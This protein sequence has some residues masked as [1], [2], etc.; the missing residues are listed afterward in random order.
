MALLE[1]FEPHKEASA[2]FTP[3][4][5]A[6]GQS[7]YNP[8]VWKRED[9]EDLIEGF[10][11]PRARKPFSLKTRL[12]VMAKT[13]G[14]CYS[15]GEKFNDPSEVWIEHIIAFSVGGS[16][17][18]DNLLPGC[19]ICNYTRQNF[20]PHQIKRILSIGS[21]MVREIDKET[22]F[23]NAALNFLE[24]EDARRTAKR[25]HQDQ[26]FLVYKRN[27]QGSSSKRTMREQLKAAKPQ[28]H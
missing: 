11:R 3:C 12:E 26:S 22:E 5:S 21:V 23:G 20:T 4:G 8:N 10:R 17:E 19:H 18:L 6:W 2:I 1:L 24:K 25:K 9:G 13:G 14:H 27:A 7:P 16:D 15:C 28:R